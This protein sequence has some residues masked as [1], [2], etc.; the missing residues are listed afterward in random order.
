[1]RETEIVRRLGQLRQRRNRAVIEGIG[2]D[3]A[4]IRP[5]ANADLVFTTDFVLEDRHFALNTHQPEAIGHKA[6]ARSLSDLAAMGSE[7][8]FFLVS[9]ALPEKL[10]DKWI[11]RFYKGL[12]K[13]AHEHKITLAGGDLSKF[14]KVIVDVMCCGRVSKGGALLRG[15]ASAGDN[16]YVTGVL[17]A[18]AASNW[19]RAPEPRVAA[20]RRLRKIA[21]SC[22]DLSDGI[23]LDLT[24]LCIESGV[25]AELSSD[26]IPIAEGATLEQAL[27]GGEDYEL[28]FTCPGDVR[29]PKHFGRLPV[30]HIGVVNSKKKGGVT[31]DGRPLPAAGFDHFAT[32]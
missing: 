2:D 24:R 30:T 3:C 28:L 29:V 31:L 26:S 17:G 14:D 15:G 20:G 9:L 8:M 12:L 27:H 5:P 1:M 10:T 21:S 13:L 22:I 23:S 11:D 7:P 6:L 19:Q 16:I 32:H 25:G 4:V 18:A